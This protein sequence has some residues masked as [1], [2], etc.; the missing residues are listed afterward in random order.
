MNSQLHAVEN[1]VRLGPGPHLFAGAPPTCTGELLITNESD[2]RL[3]LRTVKVVGLDDEAAQGLGFAELTLST[4]VGPR[5]K[6][7]A[8]G[9]IRIDPRTPPGRYRAELTLG[10]QRAP[11]I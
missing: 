6:T 11:I 3:W 1:A 10:D 5:A 4:R 7:R 9:R 2:G 8:R